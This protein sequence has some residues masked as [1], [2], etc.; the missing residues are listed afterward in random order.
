MRG[1]DA[2][3]D[4]ITMVLKAGRVS[5]LTP[6]YTPLSF[7]YPHV[8]GFRGEATRWNLL[9]LP[10][11]AWPLAAGQGALESGT[12]DV[13]ILISPTKF[14]VI[15]QLRAPVAYRMPEERGILLTIFGY[16]PPD[17]VGTTSR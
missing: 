12:R 7:R 3:R 11:A 13:E 4:S 8:V 16:E 17:I 2:L 1:T 6:F 5:L 10:E 9:C 15:P 14:R